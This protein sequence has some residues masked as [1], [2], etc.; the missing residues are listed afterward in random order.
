MV[1]VLGNFGC[2]EDM[3]HPVTV[4]LNKKGG[5]YDS[6]FET[7]IIQLVQ[8]FFQIDADVPG[9]RFLVKVDSG[10]GR[11]KEKFLPRIRSR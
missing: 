7:Y 8:S 3:Y 2:G 6:E 9:K 10:T 1:N 4:G 11:H 5:T